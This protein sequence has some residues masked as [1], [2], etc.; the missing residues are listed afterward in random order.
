MIKIVR[1]DLGQYTGQQTVS[2]HA[3]CTMDLLNISV[4]L[5][6]YTN[7]ETRVVKNHVNL[8]N[9]LKNHIACSH[10]L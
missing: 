9:V 6:N 1:I 8:T 3:G 2:G 4:D 5:L 10:S 7:T